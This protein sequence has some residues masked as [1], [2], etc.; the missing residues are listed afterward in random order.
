MLPIIGIIAVIIAVI[1]GFLFEHGNLSVLI[2]PAELVI[3]AG[4][5]LG[6]FIISSPKKV[7]TLV[8][9]NIILIF[10]TEKIDAKFYMELLMMLYELFWKTRKE[11]LLAIES[12]LANPEQSPILQNYKDI[13]EN[14]LVLNFICD[15]MKVVSNTNLP[16]HKLDYLLEIDIDAT[17]H[18]SL[19]PPNII[20][21]IADSLPGLGIVAA[22]LGVVLTMG[23]INEPPAILGGS[24]GAALVGTFLGV[25]LCYGFVSPMATNLEHQANEQQILLNVIRNALVAFV[26]GMAPQVALEAGRR[27]I[28]VKDRPPSQEIEDRIKEWK[29]K[30]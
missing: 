14:K 6:A 25:L 7:I 11:G 9:N 29:K 3:I 19:I 17:H 4:S 1:G 15:S 12:D 2:Q 26:D 22:V 30:K 8:A 13:L 27:A 10:K 28:P 24:I 20:S 16:A 21:K 5:A 18:E 23:K